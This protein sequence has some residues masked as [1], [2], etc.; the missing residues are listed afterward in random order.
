M[1]DLLVNDV[2]KE[3]PEGLPEKKRKGPPDKRVADICTAIDRARQEQGYTNIVNVLE[4]AGVAESTW[5]AW[6]KGE[7]EPDFTRL[8]DVAK[9]VGLGVGLVL[10]ADM[11]E[12]FL[13]GA[14]HMPSELAQTIATLV[15]RLE[16]DKQKLEALFEVRRIVQKYVSG[17]RPP[18]RGD[19]S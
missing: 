3:R 2:P 10:N 17:S 7:T 1:T 15:D 6:R 18:P 8:D 19:D 14:H 16:S 4:Q 12:L 11:Q 9:V 5:H 13:R